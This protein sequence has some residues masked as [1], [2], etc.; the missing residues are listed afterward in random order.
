MDKAVKKALRVVLEEGLEATL[1]TVVKVLGSVPR[2][3]GA[4]M[5]VFAD[6][7]TAGTIGGGC[8]EADAKREA[9]QVMTT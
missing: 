9:L 2:K 7:T 3:P 1:I 6:G 8:G 5:L 4:Q